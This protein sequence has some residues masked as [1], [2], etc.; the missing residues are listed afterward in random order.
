MR[1]YL[2]LMLAA[3]LL[4][5][6]ACS[7]GDASAHSG[8]ADS[9]MHVLDS[10]IENRSLYLQ[11][12][13]VRIAQAR[14]N[15]E[16]ARGGRELFDAYNR[17]FGEYQPFNS[18]SA[19]AVSL[20][21][22]SVARQTGD[23][24]MLLNARL[25]RAKMLAA[26]GMY[27]ET[28][29][30]MDSIQLHHLPE[31]MHGYYYHIK[32]TVYGCM[33]DYA[34]FSRQKLH[35]QRLTD[36]YRD[37][38]LSINTPGTLGY[39][40]SEADQL[41]VHGRPAEAVRI[42]DGFMRAN[43]LSEHEVAIC[44]WTLADSYNRLGDTEEQKIQLTLSAISDM[45]SC[46]REYVS[47][48]ELAL[49]LYRE[50]DLARA[51]RFMGIAVDDATLCNARQRIIELND[52]YPMINGIYVETVQ[53]QKSRLEWA[54]G[55]ITL[56][57]LVLV[58]VLLYLRQQVRRTNRA[59][60]ETEEA[61]RRVNALADELRASNE[62]L[63]EA[64]AAIAEN[65]ELKEVYIGRYMDQCLSYIDKID[66]YRRNIAKLHNS[67]K[68]AELSRTLKSTQFIDQELKSFYDQFDR[69]FLSI[70]PTFVADL[71]AL[72]ADGEELTPKREGALS[73]EL[74]IFALIR[75]GITDSDSIA[76]F[77]RYS[78]TT[79]Y[80]YRTKV[81]NKARGDRNTLEAAVARI[82]RAR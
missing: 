30:I 80:N 38:L 4:S 77:L 28:L 63:S 82:G 34:A 40:I 2:F 49:L 42:M 61:Y 16:A 5:L 44:A 10:V 54:I 52:T 32:R 60:R 76:R 25:N 53:S 62:M 22:E 47:L 36:M 48:R 65:S 66:V 79:I 17:L 21:Q 39:A 50:G 26:T 71:N 41:N 55:S 81:R 24:E 78:I 43:K 69:T 68:T 8:Q 20:R 75:L 51:Y 56:L 59:R 13:E 35:Y 12:K 15:L 72:L 27:H 46:V 6:G 45:K 67:G 70:F 31:Y 74:R 37:S 57:A 18:D 7:V 73:P 33:A 58:A 3:V 11:E 64:N 14:A 23:R 19:F 9:L 29:A 1:F